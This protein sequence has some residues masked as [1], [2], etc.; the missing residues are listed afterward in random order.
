M[1]NPHLSRTIRSSL[2]RGSGGTDS[3]PISVHSLRASVLLRTI[4]GLKSHDRGRNGSLA[5]SGS[6]IRSVARSTATLTP[7]GST[8][9][10]NHSTTS[11]A[12]ERPDSK[13][14]PDSASVTSVRTCAT[15]KG[16]HVVGRH[17]HDVYT[18]IQYKRL[19]FARKRTGWR[20]RRRP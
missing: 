2:L 14:T 18:L 7:T 15:D 12:S 13:L 16:Q 8:R 4:P 5:S 10:R 3:D 6:S 9:M 1:R 20:W 11:R 19:G 17:H